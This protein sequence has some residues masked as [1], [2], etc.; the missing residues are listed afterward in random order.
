MRNDKFKLKSS[1]AG[2]TGFSYNDILDSYNIYIKWSDLPRSQTDISKENPIFAT[3]PDVLK[4][5]I[6]YSP[7]GIDGIEFTIKQKNLLNILK[8]NDGWATGDEIMF[9]FT[10]N[11]VTNLTTQDLNGIPIQDFIKLGIRIKKSS[12][13]INSEANIKIGNIVQLYD[14]NI[15]NGVNV[16]PMEIN[17]DIDILKFRLV[18]GKSIVNTE[19]ND[20]EIRWRI[21]RNINNTSWEDLT[22][23]FNDDDVASLSS[24]IDNNNISLA[25]CSNKV[26]TSTSINSALKSVV[27]FEDIKGVK[28]HDDGTTH[29]Y[30]TVPLVKESSE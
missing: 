2:F 16:L 15:D 4:Q 12:L 25:L 1:R 22:V 14:K 8:F 6:D 17:E 3:D 18:N 10:D 20:N 29:Y 9:G 26:R 13:D 24:E 19:T 11:R 30:E 28:Y 21:F 5:N 27:L 7:K 23:E